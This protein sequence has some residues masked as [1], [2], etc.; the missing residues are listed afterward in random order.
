[1]TS[2]NTNEWS[3]SIDEPFFATL[4]TEIKGTK[5]GKYKNTLIR[6]IYVDLEKVIKYIDVDLYK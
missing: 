1:M 3:T 5:S 4:K 2:I 6:N